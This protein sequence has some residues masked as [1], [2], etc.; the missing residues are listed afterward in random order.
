MHATLMEAPS[1]GKHQSGGAQNQS[2]TWHAMAHSGA[3]RT[4]VTKMPGG[5]RAKGRAWCVANNT[6]TPAC[7]RI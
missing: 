4:D 6:A 5:R 3:A 1:S 7:G 2:D